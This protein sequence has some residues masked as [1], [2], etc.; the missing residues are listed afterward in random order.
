M[1]SCAHNLPHDH[2]HIKTALR[3]FIGHSHDDPVHIAQ[4]MDLAL[5]YALQMDFAAN[6]VKHLGAAVGVL[7]GQLVV[8]G[9][10]AGA[11]Q[12]DGM[13]DR[14]GEGMP[15]P[16]CPSKREF[17]VLD[18]A[19]HPLVVRGKDQ[20]PGR[21]FLEACE[22][23]GRGAL[24][25]FRMGVSLKEGR[26]L[27]DV[28]HARFEAMNGTDIR[29]FCKAHDR[30]DMESLKPCVPGTE[31]VLEAVQE[32]PGFLQRIGIFLGEDA[33]AVVADLLLKDAAVVVA[34]DD[35]LRNGA[36]AKDTSLL[37]L[38]RPV[39]WGIRD[40][41]LIVLDLHTEQVSP[42]I[43]QEIGLQRV[44]RLGGMG[45][46]RV[47]NPTALAVVNDLGGI[48]LAECAYFGP[49]VEFDMGERGKCPREA[50]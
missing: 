36:A 8:G 1:R 21:Y 45:N 12:R 49:V 29:V 19:V 38:H 3:E 32:V 48:L 17:A 16:I 41:T 33:L 35:R 11:L 23:P 47:A 43:H 6:A 30:N 28:D 42:R 37:D 4:L 22:N 34:V 9:E 40:A 27:R 26:D 44:P 10:K 46:D 50:I 7:Y 39:L 31:V 24:G 18:D 14:V 25:E 2:I 13:D 5:S 20:I 15:A